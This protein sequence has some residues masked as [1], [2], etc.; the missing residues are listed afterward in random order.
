MNAARVGERLKYKKRE[1]I[2]SVVFIFLFLA[3]CPGFIVNMIRIPRWG[4]FC[5]ACILISG[6]YFM[7]DS[8]HHGF[9]RYVLVMTIFFVYLNGVTIFT[10]F[11]E[12]RYSTVRMVKCLTMVFMVEYIV[13]WYGYKY[14]TKILMTLMEIT[15]Y[16]NAICMMIFPNGLY[17]TVTINGIDTVIKNASDFVRTKERVHW[18]L[19]HQTTMIRF[20]LL[21]ICVS[22]IYA[23]I[24]DRNIV[25]NK[26][27]ILVLTKRSILLIGICILEM[28]MANSAGNFVF[29][30][31]FF[32]LLF[33]HSKRNYIKTWHML[34][35][36]VLFYGVAASVLANSYV[37]DWMGRLLHRTVDLLARIQIWE[38]AFAAF[39]KSPIWG[40]GYINEFGRIRDILPGVGNPHSDYFWILY[41]GGAIGIVLFVMGLM[42][43]GRK[44]ENSTNKISIV[45][46]TAF[47]CFMIMML[48]DDH[49]FRSQYA[50]IFMSLCYYAPTMALGGKTDR[51]FYINT[52]YGGE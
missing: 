18:L 3:Y 21:A 48:D 1:F 33:F 11:R 9:N 52:D 12:L 2:S 34:L 28:I 19:G 16:I 26:R 40:N 42:I 30:G 23:L 20:L 25:V 47:L 5:T 4:Q 50:L 17:R 24:E 35:A 36:I 45:A 43:A 27:K 14:L 41:E 29:I 46:Y 13:H 39:L 32:L 15:N 6:L 44:C 7:F 8:F 31:L 10:D 51:K 49:I 37:I 22:I 38:A